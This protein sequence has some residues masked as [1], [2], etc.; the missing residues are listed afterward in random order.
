MS[1]ETPSDRRFWDRR[2]VSTASLLIG[3]SLAGLEGTVITT[4][5]P[6]AVGSLGG[7]SI[8]AWAITTFLLAAAVSIPP[9]GKLADIYGRKRMFLAGVGV[10]VIGSIACGFAQSMIQLIILRFIQGIGGGAMLALPQ[11]ILGTIYPEEKRGE[12]LGYANV[13]WGLSSFAGPI[14]G[15]AILSVLNWRWA[16]FLPAL[17]GVVGFALAWLS[18]DESTGEAESSVDY[19]GAIALTIGIAAILVAL[20]EAGSLTLDPLILGLLAVGVVGLV[21]FYLIERR[22]PEP[23]VPLSFFEN[24]TF[25]ATVIACFCA[26]FVAYVAIT[27]V[28]LLLQSLSG[29]AAGAA[30]GVFPAVVGWAIMGYVGGWAVPR[31]GARRLVL[32]GAVLLILG[33]GWTATW[34][35]GT[36]LP[37]RLASVFLIGCGAGTIITPALTAL[38]NTYGTEQMGTVTSSFILAQTLGGAVGPVVMGV[39]MNVVIRRE[40]APVPGFA[41]LGDI[42]RVLFLGAESLPG[43]VGQ[44]MVAGVTFAFALSLVLCAISLAAGYFVPSPTLSE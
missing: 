35:V 22:A 44:A 10:F 20:E 28:P 5:L 15:F 9:W 26:S 14:I 29:S 32:A 25:V 16:F 13:T 4:A 24:T 31:V 37:I 34:S 42:Q 17:I 39:A 33:T 6:S 36:S 41:T 2:G 30:F 11:T 27:F 1:Y 19:L 21:G 3:V 38:Q 40:L 43:A 12:A 8:Y 23:L 7:L 18:L